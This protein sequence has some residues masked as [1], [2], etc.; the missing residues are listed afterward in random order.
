MTP[1]ICPGLHLVHGEAFDKLYKV[2]DVENKVVQ[3]KRARDILH[4]AWV[5]IR[6][7]GTPYCLLKDNIN[8]QSNM[9][10]VAPICS[11]NLCAEITIPSW[12]DFEAKQFGAEHGETGVCNLGAICLEAFIIDPMATPKHNSANR[13]EKITD[14]KTDEKPKLISFNE[15]LNPKRGMVAEM[16]ELAEYLAKSPVKIDFKGIVDA[17]YAAS[18]ALDRIIDINFTPVEQGRR[19]NLRHR[20]IGVG[21]MGLA[22]VFARLSIGYGSALA[23]AL[24]RA[25]AAAIYY[26]ASLASSHTAE[27]IAQSGGVGHYESFPGSPASKGMLQPDLCARAGKHVVA[28]EKEL[29]PVLG[30]VITTSDWCALRARFKK[31]WLRN[32]YVTAYMPTA[33]TSNIIGANECF[34]PYTSN[35]YV[36]KTLAGEFIIINRHLVR[37]LKRKGLWSDTMRRKIIAAGGSVQGLV[38]PKTARLFLTAREL[39]Q[40][41]LMFHAHARL[42]FTSQSMSLN[43]YYANFTMEDMVTRLVIAKELGLP[44]A[45]YYCHSAPATGGQQSSIRGE[46]AAG[47]AA[48]PLPPPPPPRNPP[49]PPN[50]EAV[51]LSVQINEVEDGPDGAAAAQKKVVSNGYSGEFDTCTSCHL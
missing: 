39:D 40:R 41:L 25:I 9:Q 8:A 16:K 28:W 2:Y 11:S 1:D 42:P 32:A 34:E 10:N 19:S 17:A 22:D 36:R 12:S 35:I 30:H 24:D 48:P 33:T 49:Y 46:G 27:R 21:E 31:G 45:W 44:C 14:E 50:N 20:P 47:G 29:E 18:V 3:R 43:G 6:L 37:V 26:G 7:G 4:E 38:D 23:R 5:T 13:D 15:M 51:H